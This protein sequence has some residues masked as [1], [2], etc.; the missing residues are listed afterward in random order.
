MGESDDAKHG[1]TSRKVGKIRNRALELL[2]DASLHADGIGDDLYEAAVA[3]L[4]IA[5]KILERSQVIADRLFDLG[6]GRLEP[7]RLMRVDVEGSKPASVRFVVR[8]ASARAAHVEV[9]VTWDGP[10]ELE[11]HVGRPELAAD[12]E[13]WVEVPVPASHLAGKKVWAGTARVWLSYED[14]YRDEG[15]EAPGKE[16]EGKDAQDNA[17][18]RKHGRRRVE[19]PP[20]DFEIWV[21]GGE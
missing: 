12:R 17:A 2:A 3:Q 15:K 19:L 13:T 11:G 7:S 16:A 5:S 20:R 4:D 8:N 10:G 21:A 9:E 18:Q 14:R 1:A 6:A